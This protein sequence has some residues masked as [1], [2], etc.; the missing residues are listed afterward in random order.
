M[1]TVPIEPESSLRCIHRLILAF[2]PE[3]SSDCRGMR[4]PATV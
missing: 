1:H 3:K 2:D 4:N